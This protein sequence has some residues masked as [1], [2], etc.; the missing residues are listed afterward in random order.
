MTTDK[1]L[2]IPLL[3]INIAICIIIFLFG[4]WPFSFWPRNEVSRLEGQPSLRFQKP[5][6]A[7]TREPSNLFTDQHANTD[8]IS[9]ELWLRPELLQ[10]NRGYPWYY[11]HI[12]T[13]LNDKGE[14]LIL[15]QWRSNLNIRKPVQSAFFQK[16]YQEIGLKDALATDRQQFITVTSGKAGTS[17]YLNGH[18][19]CYYPN[20][21]LLTAGWNQPERLILGNSAGGKNP[22]TGAILG[23]AIYNQT[24][25]AERVSSHYNAWLQYGA[26]HFET[27]EEKPALLYLFDE[28]DG[29]LVYD[30]A[31]NSHHLIVPAIFDAPE[32]IILSLPSKDYLTKRS[33]IKDTV[34]NIVGFIPFG[35]FF[36]IY[37]DRV[38]S[39]SR[40][41]SS[42]WTLLAGS[43]ISLIIELLQVYMPV[44]SSSLPDLITNITGTFIGVLLY[45]RILR[46]SI[47]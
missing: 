16:R 26:P 43:G 37:L 11:S 36:V 45:H 6:I 31:G 5:G 13:F 35:F 1:K 29:Q 8:A 9:I 42:L 47:G 20:Y 40:Y 18:L 19:A 2:H 15:G 3:T 17:I 28:K 12:L 27:R 4:L 33:F 23:L 22:W 41:R 24:L 7:Y 32:K 10:D 21:S 34:L 39:L 30:H 25:T 46:P 44:R 14:H 38:M